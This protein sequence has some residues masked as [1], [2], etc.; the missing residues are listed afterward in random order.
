MPL[1]RS[2]AAVAAFAALASPALAQQQVTTTYGPFSITTATGTQLS[3]PLYSVTVTTQG[4][5]QVRYNA[6]AGHCSD[7]RARIQVDGVERGV[8]DF[9]SPGQSSAFVDVGPVAA[10]QH[11]V[12]LQGEGRVSGCNAGALVGW[13]G[14]M[15]V[16]TS[17]AASQPATS[18][19]GPGLAATFLAFSLG[20][21]FLGPWRR[22]R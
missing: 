7:V 18:V 21:Y 17:A 19:P 10:G 3:G 20:A 9:L 6:S 5:L 13:G 8:T 14:T 2:A 12:A 1:L 15:D 22:R 16:M 4:V 11:V